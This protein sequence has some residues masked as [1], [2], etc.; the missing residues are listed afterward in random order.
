MQSRLHTVGKKI[1]NFVPWIG[2]T[3]E[4]HIRGRDLLFL[5][6]WSLLYFQQSEV[7]QSPGQKH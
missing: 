7:V 3:A 6:L 4:G 2:R 5:S 1:A